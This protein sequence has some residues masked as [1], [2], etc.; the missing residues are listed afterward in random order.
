MFG[1]VPFVNVMEWSSAWIVAAFA[2]DFL[3]S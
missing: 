3:S 2:F 1:M